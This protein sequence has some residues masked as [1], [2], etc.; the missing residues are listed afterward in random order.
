MCSSSA[1]GSRL[2]GRN[3]LSSEPCSASALTDAN[4][5]QPAKKASVAE[6]RLSAAASWI[7]A[8]NA[9]SRSFGGSLVRKG[10]SNV[11]SESPMHVLLHGVS[12]LT[13]CRRSGARLCNSR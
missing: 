6:K 11:R 9:A 4:L 5:A 12:I 8:A 2:L 1:H 7:N 13:Y 3:K 10:T